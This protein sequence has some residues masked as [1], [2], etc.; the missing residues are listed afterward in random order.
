MIY[1]ISGELSGVGSLAI[2]PESFSLPPGL[3]SEKY[4][5]P[6]SPK[7]ASS[8]GNLIWS[9]ILTILSVTT[10]SRRAH[11]KEPLLRSCG[12]GLSEEQNASIPSLC[13]NLQEAVVS[14]MIRKDART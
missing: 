6:P 4:P 10:V 8:M 9:Q 1:S 13:M 14:A 5:S 11:R 3:V 7:K 12:S 2:G